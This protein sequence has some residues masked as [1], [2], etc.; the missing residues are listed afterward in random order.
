VS[1][2]IQL[3][4][5]AQDEELEHENQSTCHLP[6]GNGDT[7]DL[8]HVGGK[9]RT[10]DGKVKSWRRKLAEKNVEQENSASGDTESDS[11]PK[12]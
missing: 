1:E 12:L 8:N 4:L 3:V 10:T 11:R 7:E 5:M 2:K 9:S 6:S